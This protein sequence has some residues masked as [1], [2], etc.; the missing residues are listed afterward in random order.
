MTARNVTAIGGGL[1]HVNRHRAGEVLLLQHIVDRHPLPRERPANEHDPAA[2]LTR[3]GV[4]PGNEPLGA[5][6]GAH[7]DTVEAQECENR[8]MSDEAT[9]WYWDLR[10]DVA[11]PADQRG[12]AD[13]MLGPY[14]SRV[15]AENW[16]AK[17]AE[18]NEAWDES[19]EEW[20]SG[21]S[22]DPK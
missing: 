3:E 9:E 4:S 12:P 19:D 1:D 15:E 21:G 17:V 18:R 8:P 16:K 14:S 10:R 5:Q 22:D 7:G 13:D 2:V 20:N 11:V 6:D